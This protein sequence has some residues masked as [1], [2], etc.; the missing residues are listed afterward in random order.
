ML[1]STKKWQDNLSFHL[2]NVACACIPTVWP[3]ASNKSLQF[4]ALS[5]LPGPQSK[6]GAGCQKHCMLLTDPDCQSDVEMV[7][8][9]C[10]VSNTDV[11]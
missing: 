5:P 6:Y 10:Q 1:L 11:G 7:Q 4:A 2:A 8:V 9:V 3:S